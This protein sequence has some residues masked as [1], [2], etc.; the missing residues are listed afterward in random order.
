MPE[1]LV[2]MKPASITPGWLS[3][4]SAPAPQDWNQRSR[5]AA[6]SSAAGHQGRGDLNI[7][8]HRGHL[9]GI[10]GDHQPHVGRG[11]SHPVEL[12]IRKDARLEPNQYCA[13]IRVFLGTL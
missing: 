4:P 6:T 9:A 3:R 2:R 13:H 1:L 12:D 10:G 8:Q 5:G 7:I 11:L